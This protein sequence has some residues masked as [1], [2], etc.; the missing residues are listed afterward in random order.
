LGYAGTVTAAGTYVHCGVGDTNGGNNYYACAR[1]NRGAKV[2]VLGERNGWVKI[3][4]PP[5]C[6]SVIAELGVSVDITGTKGTVVRDRAWVRAAGALR[7]ARFTAGQMRMRRGDTVKILGEVTDDY[8]KWYKIK[9]PRG[10]YFWIYGKFV[11]KPSSAASVPTTNPSAA[12]TQPGTYPLTTQPIEDD[13]P[14]VPKET[15]SAFRA[16]Q[17]AVT[18]EYQRPAN[19]RDLTALIEQ[20]KAINLKRKSPLIPY[21]D[22]YIHY[23]KSGITRGKDL[24]APEKLRQE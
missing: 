6:H 18:L 13:L 11:T 4:P 21:V 20:F 24:S 23:F 9:P 5:G 10:V 17:H 8:G 1:L 15:M 19:Q 3:A 14:A 16:A 7:L 12:T 2:Q 22:F